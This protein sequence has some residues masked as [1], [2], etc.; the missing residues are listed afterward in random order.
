MIRRKRRLVDDTADGPYESAAETT[1]AKGPKKGIKK[2]GRHLF[3]STVFLAQGF[4]KVFTTHQGF[5][6]KEKTS[7]PCGFK[8]FHGA[9]GRIRTADLILTNCRRAFRPLLHKAFRQ[10]FI[11]KG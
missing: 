9:A 7:K 11:Q 2:D 3:V 6:L 1:E 8:V 5:H 10:F 4:L